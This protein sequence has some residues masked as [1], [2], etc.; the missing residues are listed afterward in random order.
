VGQSLVQGF[1]TV[2]KVRVFADD[3]Y[4]DLT[5]RRLDV[6]DDIPPDREVEVG[7]ILDA[8]TL[9]HLLVQPFAMVGQRHLVDRADVDGRDDFLAVYVAEEC[10]LSPLFLIDRTVG[11][12]E[13]YVR[14]DPRAHKLLDRMLGGLGFQLARSR[15]IRQKRDVDKQGALMPYFVAELPDG[16]KKREAFNI[17]DRAADFAQNEFGR[18]FLFADEV[19]DFIGDVGND[20]Y[21][22][23]EVV[24]LALLLQDAGIDAACGGVVGSLGRDAREA[25]VVAEIEIGF[26][27]IIGDVDFAVLEGAHRAGINVQV[28]IKLT[29]ADPVAPRLQQRA[30]ERRRRGLFPRRIPR[31]R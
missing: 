26:S 23:A 6:M 30:P 16:L 21:R 5:F 9:H 7:D 19:L 3:G 10:D 28:G 8:E 27:A 15:D 22:C 20:L 29:Q 12:A 17:S 18:A 24:A 31:R 11:T 13:K 4:R 1:I 25:F 2:G 14:P